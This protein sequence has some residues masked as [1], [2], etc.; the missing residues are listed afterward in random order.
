MI[1]PGSAFLKLDRWN[2]LW[3]AISLPNSE[4]EV[5][6]AN[7]TTHRPERPDHEACQVLRPGDH[8]YIRHDSCIYYRGARLISADLLE[9]RVATGV[10]PRHETASREL[11]RKIQD[12]AL[13]SRETDVAVKRAVRDTLSREETEPS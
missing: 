13:T 3:F 4:G 1:E 8:L 6:I 10:S 5:A 2:H 12:A 7:L 9:D 11:L